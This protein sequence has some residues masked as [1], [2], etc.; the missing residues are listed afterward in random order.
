MRAV[1]T[2]RE[3]EPTS[4]VDDCSREAEVISAPA[5]AMDMRM[6]TEDFFCQ[7]AKSCS[8]YQVVEQ[9]GVVRVYLPK[10]CVGQS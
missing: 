2:C 10:L 6:E 7:G 9:C 8:L 4:V 3:S 1:D 5:A